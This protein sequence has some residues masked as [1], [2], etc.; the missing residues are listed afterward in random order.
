MTLTAGAKAPSFNF[1]DHAGKEWKYP[2]DFKDHK[3]AIFFLRHLGCP[4]CKE[5]VDELKASFAAFDAK[6][7]ALV[8]VVQ[9]TPKRVADYA[10]KA[11]LPYS[12]VPDR[13]KRLYDLFDVKK[14]GLREF[15]APAAFKATIRATFK[16]HLHGMFEGD[17]FQVPASFLLSGSGQVVYAHYGKDVSDFGSVTDLLASA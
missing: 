17:E 15:T 9:S 5:K 16:G 7:A 10:A 13:E 6:K 1:I 12:L 4:L 14:G 3:V 8:A 2:D 11:A